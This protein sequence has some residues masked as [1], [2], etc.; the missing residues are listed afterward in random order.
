MDENERDNDLEE[1]DERDVNPS[2]GQEKTD[3]AEGSYI[4]S[5]YHPGLCFFG[6]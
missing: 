4:I 1:Q 6:L 5:C 3:V 2:E